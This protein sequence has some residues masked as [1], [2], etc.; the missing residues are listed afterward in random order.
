MSE[1]AAKDRAV[2]AMDKAVELLEL[3]SRDLALAA[4]TAG[5]VTQNPARFAVQFP[6]NASVDG[7]AGFAQET[8]GLRQQVGGL[9][10]RLRREP[11]RKKAGG[12]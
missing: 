1:A 10:Q 8:L 11:H 7:L 4:A 2:E 3:A 12:R 5:D 9:A 6:D